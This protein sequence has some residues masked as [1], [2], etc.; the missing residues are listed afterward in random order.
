[1]YEQLKKHALYYLV[2]GILFSIVIVSNIAI[3]KYNK[4]LEDVAKKLKRVKV[5]LVKMEEAS[6][7]M[8]E[9]VSRV[10]KYVPPSFFEGS[11]EG[12]L[13]SAL[14][15]LKKEL[16]W[17]EVSATNTVEKKNEILLPLKIAGPINSYPEVVNG[18]GYLRSMSF[19]FFKTSTVNLIRKVDKG[20]AS[21]SFIIVGEM[22]MPK[23]GK[24][25]GKKPK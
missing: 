23:K 18:A 16:N 1:M 3:G 14:D 6:R 2:F 24:L 9:L 19:P 11:T 17:S 20:G 15:S 5:N 13:F 21:V 8:E 7:E 10:N 12:E 4:S 25:A 22:H